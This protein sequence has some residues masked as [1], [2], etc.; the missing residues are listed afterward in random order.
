V[1]PHLAGLPP[2][3]PAKA[4]AP[5]SLEAEVLSTSLDLLAAEESLERAKGVAKDALIRV[6]WCRL[7]HRAAAALLRKSRRRAP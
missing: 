7:N 2:A 6:R 5:S 3:A 1:K 4:Q